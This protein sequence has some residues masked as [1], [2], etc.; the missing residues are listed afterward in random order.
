MGRKTVRVDIPTRYP[1]KF[2][3]L[4]ADIWK[5]HEALGASSP[6][7]NNSLIDMSKYEVNMTE[8]LQAREQAEEHYVEAHVLMER[9]RHLMGI[10]KGQSINDEGLYNYIDTIKRILLIKYPGI[11]N[12]LET[13]GFNVVV[14]SS[15][16]PV[17]KKKK[18]PFGGQP[19]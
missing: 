10:D 18:P 5:K 17:R 7:F 13:W 4:I 9:S 3:K 12:E 16:H 8:A 14:G 2:T 6:L 19:K 1:E 11:E 15:K